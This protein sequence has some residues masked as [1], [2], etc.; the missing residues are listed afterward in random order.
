MGNNRGWKLLVFRGS[1]MCGHFDPQNIRGFKK[2]CYL[3][4]LLPYY[5]FLR[6]IMLYFN[7]IKFREWA[8][9]VGMAFELHVANLNF[10]PQQ[11]LFPWALPGV[12]FEHRVRSKPWALPSVVLK[13]TSKWNSE[14][15]RR[16]SKEAG[17]VPEW[18]WFKSQLHEG[19]LL[20]KEQEEVLSTRVQSRKNKFLCGMWLS[21]SEY[22]LWQRSYFEKSHPHHTVR[23]PELSDLVPR[24]GKLVIQLHCQETLCTLNITWATSFQRPFLCSK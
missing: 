17:H 12:M 20:S 13:Q 4:F 19:Q 11:S 14:R 1:K 21:I 16:G 22:R 24:S 10:F 2:P 3:F 5:T 7:F 8:S 23:S 6:E 9:T 15:C 18:L